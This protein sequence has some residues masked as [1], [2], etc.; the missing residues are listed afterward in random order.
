VGKSG[1]E[2]SENAV[3]TFITDILTIKKEFCWAALPKRKPIKNLKT[4]GYYKPNNSVSDPRIT[5]SSETQV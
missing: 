3:E 2:I 5:E 1:E 4:N